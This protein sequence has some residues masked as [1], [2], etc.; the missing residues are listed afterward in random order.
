[1]YNRQCIGDVGV[2]TADGS[3]QH[4]VTRLIHTCTLMGHGM[5]SAVKEL[6]LPVQKQCHFKFTVLWQPSRF[7]AL[8][9]YLVG[10]VQPQPTA[11]EASIQ[12]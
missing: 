2:H 10:Q 7:T 9:V 4:Q 8:V 6:V 5:C 12:W 11:A 1:M 3:V